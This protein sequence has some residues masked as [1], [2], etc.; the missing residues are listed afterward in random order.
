MAWLTSCSEPHESR[1]PQS[2]PGPKA[3]VPRLKGSGLQPPNFSL[4]HSFHVSREPRSSRLSRVMSPF[5]T[6]HRE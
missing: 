3:E 4:H 2:R 1:S 6:I 5:P